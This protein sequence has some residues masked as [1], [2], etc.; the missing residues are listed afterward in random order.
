MSN[1]YI[2]EILNLTNAAGSINSTAFELTE[3]KQIVLEHLKEKAH[4]DQ[5][6]QEANILWYNSEL[7]S[8]KIDLARDIIKEAQYADWNHKNIR[9]LVL[10]NFESASLAAQNALLK[11]IEEPPANTLLILP[12]SNDNHILPTISSRC[13]TCHNLSQDSN[14]HEQQATI[15]SWPQNL[16]DALLLIEKHKDRETAI[17]LIKNLLKQE[18]LSYKQKKS[19]SQAY[20][21]LKDNLNVRLAL[22]HCFFSN[23]EKNA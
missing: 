8:F 6:F 21:D 5:A 13:L 14:N 10:L 19:L 22:E 15:V 4:S 16:T 11:L 23:L 2:A 12:V 1:F 18:E 9:V 17:N 20:L 3:I 7:A